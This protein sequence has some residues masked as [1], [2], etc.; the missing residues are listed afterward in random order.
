MILASALLSVAEMGEA[1]RRTIAGGT[2]GA[3]LMERAGAAVAAEI[4][5]RYPRQP[6]AVLCGPGNN[7]GDGF[8]AARLLAEAG[9]PVRLG[10]IGRRDALRGDAALHAA[11]WPGP[12]EALAPGLLDGAGLAVDAIF[13]AGLTRPVAG[14]PAATLKAA[15]E[16]GVTLVAVDLPSGI[17]GDSGEDLGAVAAA[18]TVTFERKKPGHLLLPGRDLC[19]EVTVA[20]IGLDPAALDRIAPQCWENGLELW[21]AILPRPAAAGHKYGRG[22]ALVFGGY[23]MTGAARLSARAAARLGAGLV[24]VAVPEAAVD[25]YAA[26][27]LSIMVTPLAAPGDLNNLLADSRFNALLIGPGAGVTDATRATA[28]KLLVT[29]RPTVLD[30]DALSVFAAMPNRLFQAV[31]GDTVLTP[32]EGEFARLFDLAGDKLE[33]A[34]AAAALSGAVVLL[35]G[36]DTVVAAPDGRASIN[37][38]APPT[39]ATAGAGDVLSGMILGLLAQGVPAFEAASAAVWI[40]GAAARAFGPGLIAEDLPEQI[41]AVL[42][43]LG[44]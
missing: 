11:R 2:Q 20:G 13:G 41:P 10:L 4:R 14:A 26:S 39:L 1:D 16:R 25:V 32:H 9:W 15:A 12:V 44:F 37:A 36:S 42:R 33:R 22:H 23:P 34:R 35:K 19:G 43:A 28:L 17:Q 5:R 3:V 27:L 24:S 18:L 31:R 6:V 21:D 29:G 8:V 40:H 7:G 30:A 38:N